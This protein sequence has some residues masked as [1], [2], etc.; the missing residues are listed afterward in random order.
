MARLKVASDTIALI[1]VYQCGNRK[2]VTVRV[3]VDA[4]GNVLKSRIYFPV[5]FS[6]TFA[7]Q[8]SGYISKGV[9]P[10]IVCVNRYSFSRNIILTQL[11][12]SH[13]K[14]NRI[15]KS[16]HLL[17]RCHGILGKDTIYMYS[18]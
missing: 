1:Q 11:L 2:E 12:T 17:L 16:S 6:A 9:I 3:E 18:H 10:N 14:E 8:Q 7:F 4:E 5:I 15:V 13:I